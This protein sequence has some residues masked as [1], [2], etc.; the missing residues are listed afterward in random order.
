MKLDGLA[1]LYKDMRAKKL[2]RIR[3][4]YRHGRVSF[5]VFFFIDGSPYQLLFGAR[6]YNVAFEIDVEK[7]FKIVPRIKDEDAYKALC[8]ALGLVFNPGNPFSPKAFFEDFS[9]HI[10]DAVP[11]DHEVRPQDVVRFRR[12]VEEAHKVYF[13]GW[14]DNT[15]RKE[16][17]R[18][19]NL[20]KT[21]ELLGQKM[22]EFCKAKNMS[23]CWTD[24]P[25]GAIP[26]TLP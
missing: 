21:R 8:N 6:G 15:L 26:V 16:H 13:C 18:P 5:D 4:D 12:D 25:Q 3:F 23:S 22:Y 19:K 10:P 7:G 20:R 17:V 11:A 9:G 24:D 1:P 2:E 14:H